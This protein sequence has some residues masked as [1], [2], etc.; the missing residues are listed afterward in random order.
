MPASLRLRTRL[1]ISSRM[2][3]ATA[4]PSMIR[5]GSPGG[6]S[7]ESSFDRRWAVGEGARSVPEV[8]DAGE[9]H[10]KAVLIGR[11]DRFGVPDGATRLDQGADAGLCRNIDVVAE[12]EVA[13]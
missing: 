7:L 3:A 10:R 12:G 6:M 1:P 11:R 4:F 2:L 8:A 9:H 5:A 13:V